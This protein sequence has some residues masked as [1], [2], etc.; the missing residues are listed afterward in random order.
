M[1]APRVLIAGGAR[2]PC[3]ARLKARADRRGIKALMLLHDDQTEC[4]VRIDEQGMLFVDDREAAVDAAFVRCDVFGSS[5]RESLAA[6]PRGQSWFSF[7][8]GWLAGRP[9]IV[10]LNR[11]MQ[12]FAG[13]KVTDL[14]LARECGLATP[15]SLVT[16]ERAAIEAF[17]QAV[18]PCVAKPV[19]G[20][21]YCKELDE[22]LRDA[23]SRD[24][25]LPLPAFVQ[26]RLIYPEYRLYRIGRSY[27]VFRVESE[28]LDYRIDNRAAMTIVEPAGS[29]V[30]PLLPAC[31]M[32]CDRLGL[33]F[34]A[35]DL[36]TRASDGALCFL[37]VNT[38][39]M[40]AV[41]DHVSD[42]LITDLILHE[43]LQGEFQ[44][45]E[46]LARTG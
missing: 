3:L 2:D 22:A 11:G 17:S 1:A 35:F 10:M 15:R 21:A 14:S 9:D 43:L 45:R 27:T 30:E 18:G 29:P 7:A 20:G 5:R 40:F 28:T 37:E 8:V 12:I 4:A 38:G 34:C 19:N 6:L 26:E 23:P 32:M 36:K 44:G 42:G 13:M 16:N 46:R 39:P 33:D 41:H 31:E 24:G 25:C